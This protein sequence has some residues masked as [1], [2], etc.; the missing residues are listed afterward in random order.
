MAKI[1]MV[2]SSRDFRDVEYQK[3]RQIL[4]DRGHEIVVASSVVGPCQGADG[5]VV[6]SQVLISKVNPADYD[7]IVF[8]GGPGAE[9]FF[10][11]KETHEVINQ[12]FNLNKIIAAICV[13]PV[14]LGKAGILAGR[15]VT[16]YPSPSSLD[17]LGK[18]GANVYSEEEVLVDGNII[19]ACGPQAADKFGTAI[20][21]ALEK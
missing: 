13:A 15:D 2:I 14:I 10:D 17:I 21:E 1:L 5:L 12:F 16:V 9:E 11:D 8:V 4:E 6:N 7:A 20:A 19:T 3:P 18:E